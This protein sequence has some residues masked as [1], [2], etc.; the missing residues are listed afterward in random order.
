[1]EVPAYYLPRPAMDHGAVTVAA[2][3]H[4]Y[5]EAV[6]QGDGRVIDYALPVPRWQFLCYLADSKEIVLHGSGDPEITR[7]EPRKADDVDPFGDRSAVYAAS[8]GIWPIFFAV[9]DKVRYNVS[10]VNACFRV[11]EA[12]DD[13]SDPFYF[14][15]ITEAA[16]RQHPW[17]QG[18]IYLLPRATFEQQPAKRRGDADV[19]I[20]QWASLVPVTPLA[21]IPVGPDD[22]PFLAEIRGHDDKALFARAT[23]D[24]EG[25]PWMDEG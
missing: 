4:L 14:F 7:F 5:A 11:A 17:R 19:H 6:A 8:D 12:A 24:P 25:F 18:M 10:L 16:L 13:P 3:E 15:S 22:F 9:T 21:K 23:A 1:M 2:F 20:A